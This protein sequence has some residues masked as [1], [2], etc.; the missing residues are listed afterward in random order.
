[1]PQVSVIITTYNYGHLIAESIDS[2]INQDYPDA[3]L[4]VVDDGSTDDTAEVVARYGERVRYLRQPHSEIAAARNHGIAEAAGDLIAFQDAD[5]VWSPNT[6]AMRVGAM[7]QHG[8]LGMVFG[9]ATVVKDGEVIVP[10]FLAERSVLRTLSIIHERPHIRIIAENAFPA[11]LKE[12]FIPIPTIIMPKRRF[13]EVGP[14]DASFK[15]MEDYE[16]YLRLA[17]RFPIGYID[18][19]LVTCRIH[20]AN[21]SCSVAA[22]NERRINLLRSFEKDPDLRAGDRTAL[23]RRLAEL[24]LESAWL[25]KEEG[26]VAAARQNYMSAWRYDRARAGAL[27]RWAALRL[28]PAFGRAGHGSV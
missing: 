6:L 28:A 5:D 12:R 3:E 4:I 15:G 11:L 24:Y 2:V 9:D 25:Q 18:Q 19:I 22:Q 14:W 27:L 16:F 10:S 17:K 20:G 8:E 21:V 26:D 23:R 7:E 13:A 1:M